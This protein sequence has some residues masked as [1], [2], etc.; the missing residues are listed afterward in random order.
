MFPS[1]GGS[2]WEKS[3]NASRWSSRKWPLKISPSDYLNRH[4]K[5]PH[6]EHAREIVAEDAA[7]YRERLLSHF[8]P[9]EAAFAALVRAFGLAAFFGEEAN[10]VDSTLRQPVEEWVSLNLPMFSLGDGGQIVRVFLDSAAELETK[11]I[12]QL[13]LRPSKYGDFGPPAGIPL[14]PK[15]WKLSL[16]PQKYLNRNLWETEKNKQNR[17]LA[18]AALVPFEKQ[19]DKEL[20]RFNEL[21]RDELSNFDVRVAQRAYSNSLL[22]AQSHLLFTRYDSQYSHEYFQRTNEFVENAFLSG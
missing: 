22:A 6:A 11:I 12:K 16:S 13:G 2:L 15:F 1:N 19:I 5:G 7:E 17:L 20:R 18:L 3:R 14:R 21:L 4:P 10:A 8:G 9:I